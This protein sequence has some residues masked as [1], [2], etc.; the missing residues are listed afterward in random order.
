MPCRVVQNKYC[1]GK[2]L[3]PLKPV[4]IYSGSCTVERCRRAAST[5]PF[6]NNVPSVA[7]QNL[8]DEPRSHGDMRNIVDAVTFDEPMMVPLNERTDILPL[9][10]LEY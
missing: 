8:V 7:R 1:E 10:R 5:Y 9:S 4:D 6:G 3:I 2:E